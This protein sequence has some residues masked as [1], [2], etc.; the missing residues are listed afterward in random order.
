MTPQRKVRLACTCVVAGVCV[1][2]AAAA[3]AVKRNCDLIDYWEE[4]EQ[5]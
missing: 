3:Y 4:E 2:L 5:P 1:A